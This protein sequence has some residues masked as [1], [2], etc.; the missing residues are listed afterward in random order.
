MVLHSS[1]TA[2]MALLFS[3]FVSVVNVNSHFTSCRVQSLKKKNLFN[4]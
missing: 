4:Y 1:Y 3:L 2:T